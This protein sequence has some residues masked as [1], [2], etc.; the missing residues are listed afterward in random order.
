MVWL[1][2]K[3]MP[4][5]QGINRKGHRSVFIS[6]YHVYLRA[7]EAFNHTPEGRALLA[8]RWRVEPTVAWLVRYQGCRRARRGGTAAA[9]CQL[10][11]ACALRNLLLWLSRV[12]RGQA[13][14]PPS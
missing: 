4:T 11:Q 3:H 10:Y 8:S 1:A 6:D 9:Q 7:A 2:P 5:A 14:R 12:R 13:A